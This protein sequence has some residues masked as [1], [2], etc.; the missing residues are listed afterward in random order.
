MDERAGAPAWIL[1]SAGIVNVVYSLVYGV[2]TLLPIAFVVLAQLAAVSDGTQTI[3][4]ALFGSVFLSVV[5]LLQLVGFF[6]T[7]LMGCVTVLGGLR[8]NRYRSK[9]LVWL[10]ALCAV[11]APVICLLVNA[12]SALNLGSLG[13]GCV[14][15]CLLGNIPTLFTL[16]IGLVAAIVAAVHMSSYIA[17]F[18]APRYD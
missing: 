13:L 17:R 1:V 18:D 4:G 6:V 11:G 3:G 2:W 12:G 7:F 9:G 8:L 5:P 15:G 16:L 10:G 14:T